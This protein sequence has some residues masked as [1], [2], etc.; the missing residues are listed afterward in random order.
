MILDDT[1]TSFP[2]FN[3]NGR[4]FLIKFRSLGKEQ[5]LSTYLKGCITAL[6][7]YLVD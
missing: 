3:T 6:T 7:N 2:K 4:S 1:S 5:E